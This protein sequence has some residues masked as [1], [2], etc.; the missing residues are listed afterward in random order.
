M[1]KSPLDSNAIF[2]FSVISGFLHKKV[3]PFRNFLQFSL[4]PPYAKSKL[5]TNSGYMRPTLFVGWGEGLGLCKLENALEM[6]KCLKTSAHD[7]LKKR[8]LRRKRSI[9]NGFQACK[10]VFS[11]SWLK[12]VIEQTFLQLFGV[13]WTCLKDSLTPNGIHQKSLYLIARAL[14]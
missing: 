6:Q 11:G 7:C 8:W 13:F 5:G 2:I 1:D 14:F 12:I 10:S 4:P 3:H 9:L